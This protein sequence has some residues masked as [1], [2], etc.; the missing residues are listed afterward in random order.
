[1][2]KNRKRIAFRSKPLS[3]RMQQLKTTTAPWKPR[4]AFRFFDLPPEIRRKILEGFVQDERTSHRDVLNLFYTC[5]TLYAE[6]AELYFHEVLEDT[7]S[8]KGRPAPFLTG[9]CS[10]IRARRYVRNLTIEF[11]LQDHMHLFSERY[12]ASVRDMVDHGK[13]ERL[14]LVI[15]THFPSSAFWG[16]DPMDMMYDEKLLG[17]RPGQPDLVAP[18]FVAEPAFQGFLEFLRGAKVKQMDVVVDAYDHHWVWCPFHRKDPEGR[19]CNGNWKSPGRLLVVDWKKAVNAMLGLRTSDHVDSGDK[20][21]D[22]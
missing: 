12:A 16:G 19:P 13:L 9:A 4:G 5:G 3:G 21:P 10:R 11:E 20:K 14:H 7:T 2:Q 6:A 22:S 18:R 1:M 17:T 15:S 8:S